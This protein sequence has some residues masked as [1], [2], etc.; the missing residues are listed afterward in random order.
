M[1]NIPESKWCA[2]K[3]Y[4]QNPDHTFDFEINY[5][6]QGSLIS[7]LNA[8]S[9]SRIIQGAT[10]TK[11]INSVCYAERAQKSP[12]TTEEAYAV[13]RGEYHGWRL[14]RVRI[15]GVSILL[16]YRQEQF[17]EEF[18]CIR[19]S[20][21]FS[22]LQMRICSG[23]SDLVCHFTPQNCNKDRESYQYITEPSVLNVYM[24]R[25]LAE[26]TWWDKFRKRGRFMDCRTIIARSMTEAHGK[27]LLRCELLAQDRNLD[28]FE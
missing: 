12:F 27:Q 13:L 20:R 17:P 5:L 9:L 15:T 10:V 18:G 19:I 26:Q 11:D 23:Y 16:T 24:C 8:A 21:E 22:E 25:G 28:P 2:V 4:H 7:D 1:K 3:L 14:C 6:R